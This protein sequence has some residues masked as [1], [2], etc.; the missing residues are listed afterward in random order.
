MSTSELV[1][2]LL[3]QGAEMIDV[4]DKIRVNVVQIQANPRIGCDKTEALDSIISEDKATATHHHNNNATSIDQTN[5]VAALNSIHCKIV[6]NNENIV[7][8]HAVATKNASF[9]VH[10]PTAQLLDVTPRNPNENKNNKI[11]P[12]ALSGLR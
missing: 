11:C 10:F 6:T 3:V 1:I 8:T 5:S 2:D 9:G 7:D 12:N 4:A